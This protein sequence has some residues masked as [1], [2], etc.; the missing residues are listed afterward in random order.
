MTLSDIQSDKKVYICKTN[1]ERAI[2][3]SIPELQDQ[4]RTEHC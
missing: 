2:Y 3:E 4:H 1:N